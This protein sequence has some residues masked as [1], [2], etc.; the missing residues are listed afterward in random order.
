MSKKKA[1]LEIFLH[2][3]SNRSKIAYMGAN[4]TDTVLA[5]TASS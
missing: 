1:A 3:I 5:I 2:N 4:Q